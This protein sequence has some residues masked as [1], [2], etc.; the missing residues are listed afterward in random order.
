MKYL[1]IQKKYAQKTKSV[2][3]FALAAIACV[4][5]V[6]SNSVLGEVSEEEIALSMGSKTWFVH[7]PLLT[8]VAALFDLGV[9]DVNGDRIFDIYTANHSEKQY[10][11]LGEGEGKFSDNAIS[12]L[13]LDQDVDFPGLEPVA[14]FAPDKPG[15]YIYWQ[16]RKLILQRYQSEGIGEF[17]GKMSFSAS[18]EQVI[19][20]DFTLDVQEESLKSGVTASRLE[21]SAEQPDAS[22]TLRPYNQSIPI[23]LSLDS[24]VSLDQVYVG[25]NRINPKQHQ[26]TLYLRDRHGMAWADYDNKGL[27]DVFIV[28]GG[29]RARMDLLP[30]RYSDELL[31]S[32]QSSGYDE[33]AEGAGLIKDACPALQTAW[34]DTNGDGRLDIY[35]VCFAPPTATRSYANQLHQQQADGRFVETAEAVGID[36]DNGGSFVW[37]DADRD[38][39]ADLLWADADA[40]WLYA[41]RSGR[42]EPQRIGPNP[43]NAVETFS[44]SSQFT[45]ADYD[46]DGDLDVFFASP[47]GNSLLVNE[48]G[49]YVVFNPA[50]F[51]LPEQAHT[52]NWVDYNNDGLSDLHTMPDGLYRQHE[53][54]TFE[55]L[56]LLGST[57]PSFQKALASWADIDNNGTRDLL[58]SQ[59]YRQSKWAQT[60]Q[61]LLRKVSNGAG[62]GASSGTSV[63]IYSNMGADLHW[64][65]IELQGTSQN[66]QAI[67]ALVEIA[68]PAG[69]Q[70]QMVGQSEGAHFSQG[71]YRL[72]FGLNTAKT[73]D[74]LRV[75]WPDG[76]SQTLSDVASD[77]LLTIEKD[78]G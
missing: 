1:P 53:N 42:F 17:S 26:F 46:N 7:Q 40:F 73:V 76:T 16:G 45:V 24:Q 56:S 38:G 19:N 71:H 66:R 2:W 11:L 22:I 67:G 6:F 51:G 18:L 34:V 9:V 20:K 13:K 70:L 49:V 10:L 35:T 78:T 8:G 68:T 77:Q 36:I 39:A 28:R 4:L 33:Q 31:V 65:Q 64:L 58:M 47:G 12:E 30:E 3:L 63:S 52:A 74:S 75:Y 41:N 61:P 62:S 15:F 50:Q 43:G 23:T 27:L 54:H 57:T 37:L 14:S 29:L 48:Q 69:T 55:K 25:N 60:V 72:Y 21:F 44:D 5:I 59:S 32:H